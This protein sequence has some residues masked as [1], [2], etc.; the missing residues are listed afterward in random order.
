LH[1]RGRASPRRPITAAYLVTGAWL[2]L[3]PWL[4]S[5]L[6]GLPPALDGLR[7]LNV[8]LLASNPIPV[9]RA[10]WDAVRIAT[11]YPTTLNGAL[12]PIW[13][14][15]LR[16]MTIQTTASVLFLTS[17]ATL[18]RPI[19]LG[20]R[21][22][23]TTLINRRVRERPPIGDDPMLWKERTSRRGPHLVML[24][25]LCL[26][27][28]WPLIEPT[29]A[30]FAERWATIP[31]G[32]SKIWARHDL[33]IRLR[34]LHTGLFVLGLA[35][36]AAASAMSITGEREQKT[37]TSLATTLLTGREVVRAKI[38]GVLWW[39]RTLAIPFL[40]IWVIGL[41]TGS[42]HPA[43]VLAAG[44]GL[45]AYSWYASALGVLGSMLSD[46]S[47]RALILT[48]LALF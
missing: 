48:F 40:I 38:F 4:E 18:L 31:Q 9:I 37:W 36:V 11:V 14:A 30:A 29:R 20:L 24:A 28:F 16:L 21:P 25:V 39:M 5:N 1:R 32:P 15:F 7:L 2:L 13:T 41:A 27:V 26:I 45:L 35:A 33:N 47:S 3:P 34:Q 43:G 12:A 22:R 46:Q 17:A 42:I 8:G 44:V 6:K 23:R 10:L 19:R